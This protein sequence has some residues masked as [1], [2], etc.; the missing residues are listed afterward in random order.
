MD[1]LLVKHQS[2]SVQNL[3]LFKLFSSCIIQWTCI[4]SI[5]IIFI[6]LWDNFGWEVWW[7]V[8]IMSHV[9]ALGICIL[10]FKVSKLI[11]FSMIV[12]DVTVWFAIVHDSWWAVWVEG[13]ILLNLILMILCMAIDTSREVTSKAQLIAIIG[14]VNF[15]LWFNVRDIST[16]SLGF[17]ISVLCA[18]SLYITFLL[19]VF[20]N[21]LQFYSCH[22]WWNVFL[23]THN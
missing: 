3:F 4:I 14:F 6:D 8:C 12:I 19:V 13:S 21:A 2:P 9:I 16:V 1:E 10:Q 17:L 20:F 5:S 23:F 18:S 22:S 11:C 15:I 7:N